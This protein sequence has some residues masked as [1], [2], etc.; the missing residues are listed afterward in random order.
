MKTGRDALTT[1]LLEDSKLDNLDDVLA[2][3]I[4]GK[5]RE[6]GHWP[7]TEPASSTIS[8]QKGTLRSVAGCDFPL[9]SHRERR[10]SDHACR[11]ERLD[12]A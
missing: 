2:T 1:I 4:I 7:P 3:F 8:Q 12:S 6:Y 9:V 11:R 5:G 10:I